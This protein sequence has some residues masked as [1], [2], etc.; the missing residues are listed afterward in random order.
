MPEP[1]L[2]PKQRAVLDAMRGGKYLGLQPS[3][4]HSLSHASYAFLCD[5]PNGDREMVHPRTAMSLVLRGLVERTAH[6]FTPDGAEIYEAPS[7]E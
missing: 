1:R 4:L 3:W 2:S 6:G 5:T 7:H